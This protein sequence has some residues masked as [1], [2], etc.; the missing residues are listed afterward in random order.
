VLDFQLP[1]H[2]Y[3][4]VLLASGL[5]LGSWLYGHQGP[6]Q[7]ASQRCEPMPSAMPV[8][9]PPPPP[10]PVH[11]KVEALA[12][13]ARGRAVALVAFEGQSYVVEPGTGV[14]DE[15]FPVFRVK[16]ITTCERHDTSRPSDEGAAITQEC[17]EVDDLQTHRIVVK[18]LGFDE[19]ASYRAKSAT[20]LTRA[21]VD[22]CKLA[23]DIAVAGGFNAVVSPAC[24]RQRL[25]LELRGVTPQEAFQRLVEISGLDVRHFTMESADEAGVDFLCPRSFLEYLPPGNIPRPPAGSCNAELWCRGDVDIAALLSLLGH[26]GDFN[27][28]SGSA[29]IRSRMFIPHLSKLSAATMVQLVA[30]CN[31]CEV[32]C[33]KESS[34]VMTYMVKQRATRSR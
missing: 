27:V 19:I 21:E 14:P 33:H 3:L 23:A 17:V 1:L 29:I 25:R 12:R 24:T 26:L 7:V 13:D 5:I 16:K 28:V 10:P 8:I 34:G 31:G 6:S 4:K 22:L 32:V 18:D 2:S 20:V 30:R 9:P 11:F 15:R